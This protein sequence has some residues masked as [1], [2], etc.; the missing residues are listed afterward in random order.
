MNI[1]C[2]KNLGIHGLGK[3]DAEIWRLF[4]IKIEKTKVMTLWCG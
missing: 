1:A 2:S 3:K 4:K